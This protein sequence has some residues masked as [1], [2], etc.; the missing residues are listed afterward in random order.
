MRP[1]K[2]TMTAFGPY[3][4]TETVD[5]TRLG[6]NR[7]FLIHGETGAG[8]TSILDGIVFALYG[9][10]SGGERSG[11]QMRCEGAAPRTLTEVELEFALGERRFRVRRSPKQQVEGNK[12]PAGATAKLWETTEAGPGEEGEHLSSRIAEVDAKVR[13]LI[14]FSC[15]QFRQVVVLPQGRFRELLAADS[16]KREEILRQLFPTWECAELERR[17]KERARGLVVEAEKLKTA[18]QTLLETVEAAD[19]AQLGALTDAAAASVGQL[20]ADEGG[21]RAAAAGAEAALLA[22]KQADEAAAAVAAA[23]ERVTALAADAPRI[24][25]LEAVAEQGRRAQRVEPHARALEQAAARRAATGEEAAQVEQ[26]L[27]EAAEREAK[28]AEVLH[29]QREREPERVRAA[30]DVRAL[31]A[32]ARTVGEWQTAERLRGEADE[33]HAAAAVELARAEAAG[34]EAGAAA[35]SAAEQVA[36]SQAAQARRESAWQRR[37]AAVL[38]VAQCEA[39]DRAATA[40][41]RT[42]AERAAAAA[43]CDEAKRAFEARQ[44]EHDAVEE[45]WRAG[46]AAALAAGLEDGAPCPVCGSTDH[47]APAPPGEG[48]GDDQLAAARELL[49]GAR[50]RYEARRADLGAADAALAAAAGELTARDGQAERELTTG[51]AR[52]AV[53]ACEQ[54]CGELDAV[55][56]AAGDADELQAQVRE[57]VQA[58]EQRLASAREAERAAVTAL[59]EKRTHAA[60]L[61]AGI[62]DELRDPDALQR[63]V[64]E[65]GERAARLAGEL[66]A[67]R[68]GD[69]AAR[70]DRLAKERDREAAIKA[71]RAAEQDERQAQEALTAALAECRFE[72]AELFAAAVRSEDDLAAAEA[73]VRGHREDLRAA[74]AQLAD[75]R[76]RVAAHPVAGALDEAQRRRDEAAAALEEVQRRLHFAQAALAK[77][78]QVR[79]SLDE[80]A[81]QNRENDELYRVVGRLS[82]VANGQTEGAKVSFQRWVLGKYLDMVLVAASERLRTMSRDRYELHRQ[83]ETSDLRRVSG[84]ELAVLDSYSSRS[85]PAVTLSGGESFLAALSLAL[86]LAETVETRSGGIRLDTIFVDEGFGAL[87]PSALESAMTALV[88]LKDTGRLV[89]VISHVPELRQVIGARLE[90]RGGPEGSTTGFH[91]P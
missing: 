85:R 9:Q 26:A 61:A 37:D 57:R 20:E 77:L 75:A 28:A 17:L 73:Q 72:T 27:A 30:D 59:A 24:E 10:T 15:E 80:L 40:V 32:M 2:L 62:P 79:E 1:L 42:T 86:G 66:E 11:Q 78:R 54:E 76:A 46:R 3:R 50:L 44:A 63:E 39:R 38:A 64:A 25:Q 55:I 82:E 41:E 36:A 52:A 53:A 48:A 58:A 51:Q 12:T 56:A 89:G 29:E 91:V 70:M 13:E 22:A 21:A 47:P 18:R 60:G 31:T 69:E 84:L 34:S 8:K 43:A 49:D 7:L 6:E 19:E 35:Q 81:R 4:A 65:A 14:G 83:Q 5:F 68:A 88:Q 74:E 16:V 87:D 33:A 45:R 67:A 71:A 90:V 23:A